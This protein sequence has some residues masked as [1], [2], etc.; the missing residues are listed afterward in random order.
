M[1]RNRKAQAAMEFLMTY[2]WAILV[3]LAAIGALAYFGVLAP[4][5]FLPEKCMMPPGIACLD[6]KVTTTQI[7]MIMQN[8]MGKDI[9]VNSISVGNCSISP[10]MTFANGDRDTFT[11]ACSTGAAGS[12][13]K[14]DIAFDYTT[15]DSGMQKVTYGTIVGKIQE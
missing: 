1:L 14:G 5:K 10:N 7:E 13:Y 4:D 12:K 2:G 15:R 6:G 9:T 3:V 8:S 11:I